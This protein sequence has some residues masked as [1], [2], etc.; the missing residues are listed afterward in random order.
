M[1]D[2]ILTEFVKRLEPR[3]EVSDFKF[4]PWANPDRRE[5]PVYQFTGSVNVILYVRVSTGAQGFW[6]LTKQLIA[7]FRS[8]GKKWAV[9]LLLRTAERGY[10]V[11]SEEVL[12]R[13]DSGEWSHYDEGDY[14][15][16]EGPTLKAGYFFNTID[17]LVLRIL[18]RGLL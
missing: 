10:L 4:S 2:P 1:P 5:E 16:S 17:E 3:A 8:S 15:V 7:D 6:R 9:V 18:T 14:E 11:P 13:T 12:R